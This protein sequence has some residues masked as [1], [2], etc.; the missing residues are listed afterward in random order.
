MDHDV[1]A[2]PG[3]GEETE[4]PVGEVVRCG[5]CGADVES[6]DDDL[7]DDDVWED[8]PAGAPPGRDRAAAAARVG[9]EMDEIHARRK[10]YNLLSFALF[11]PGFA[12]SIGGQ[13][14]LRTQDGPDADLVLLSAA[15]AAAGL[16][17]LL[18]IAG[19]GCY[20][21]YKGRNPAWGLLG[22]LSWIGLIVLA[23]LPDENKKRLIVLT[24]TLDRL[25]RR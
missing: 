14:A 18:L 15:L 4:V 13:I 24:E 5:L 22:L 12:L 1:V 10:K 16:G 23:A 9:R 8:D 20:A 7:W 21:I 25:G 2:C 11:L 19:F 6:P 3:C 17:V